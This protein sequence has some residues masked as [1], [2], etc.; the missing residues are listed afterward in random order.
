MWRT[1]EH[2]AS[3]VARS[4]WFALVRSRI[5]R[6]AGSGDR[7]PQDRRFA[8]GACWQLLG[9]RAPRAVLVAVTSGIRADRA[10]E[11]MDQHGAIDV[12]ERTVQQVKSVGASIDPSPDPG[13]YPRRP[14][15]QLFEVS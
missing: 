12:E 10:A 11:T 1:F 8:G 6:D 14:A 3:L 13:F 15:A 7:H 2:V 4:S 9:S 5:V